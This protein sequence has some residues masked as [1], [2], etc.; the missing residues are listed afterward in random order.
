MPVP[1]AAPTI[2]YNPTRSVGTPSSISYPART[3]TPPAPATRFRPPASTKSLVDRDRLIE[4]LRAQQ[5]KKLT[6]IHAPDRFRKEH[7]GRSVGQAADRGR[8]RRGVADR[9]PRRQQ[10]GLVPLA[11]DRGDPHG[12]PALATDLGEVLEEHGDEAERYVL[13][14]L[15]NEIHQ[16]GTR[17]TLVID[18]WQRVTDPA[19]SRRC[20]T[21]WTTS[22]PALRCW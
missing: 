11:S 19:T 6:V 20:A 13:T 8:R 14:S 15:I 16:S 18:D 21:C 9:R 10:R 17:M 3:L 7:A 22:H 12:T 5:D 4:V 1:I 2:R